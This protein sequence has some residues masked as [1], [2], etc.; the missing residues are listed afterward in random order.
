ILGLIL[1]NELW[2]G[3]QQAAALAKGQTW[4]QW[5]LRVAK[6]AS[7][8]AASCICHLYT[9]QA[10]PHILY[11]AELFLPPPDPHNLAKVPATFKPLYL[12]QCKATLLITGGLRSSLTNALDQ[13]AN[14]L[15]FHL[16]VSRLQRQSLLHYCTLPL[17]HPLTCFVQQAA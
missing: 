12:I 4:L 9:S 6:S 10:V 1:D 3:S 15:P 17:S 13:L 8:V 11:S 5:V 2:W 16:L 14:L 7:G